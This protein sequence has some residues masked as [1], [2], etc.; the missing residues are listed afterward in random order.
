MPKG[1]KRSKVEIQLRKYSTMYKSWKKVCCPAL[2]KDVYFT[3]KGWE[4]LFE[5]KMRTR[6]EVLERAKLL[7]IAK[8]ILSETTTI[9]GKRLQD[10][11]FTPHLHYDF[12]DMRFYGQ[13]INVVVVED[14]KKYYFLSVF[15]M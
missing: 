4:H 3:K 12:I 14:R 11:N 9:Q 2:K 10:V 7:P 6:R 1:K 8:K 13:K 5:G 15:K